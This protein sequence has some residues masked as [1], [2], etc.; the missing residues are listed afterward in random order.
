[1]RRL[2]GL[3]AAAAATAVLIAPLGPGPAQA[4]DLTFP[5]VDDFTTGSGGT[6]TGSAAIVDGRLRLTPA[7]FGRAGAWAMDDAFPSGLGLDVEF[8]YAMESSDLRHSAGSSGIQ[9]PVVRKRSAGAAVDASRSAA[10]ARV[11]SAASG[12][13][14][15]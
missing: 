8:D 12:N 1:M 14:W 9:A 13:R 15:A 7:E 3:G 5:Y 2:L 6:L 11:R 4:D 10:A